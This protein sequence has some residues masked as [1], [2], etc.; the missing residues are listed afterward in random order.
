[1]AAGTKTTEAYKKAVLSFPKYLEVPG[2]L[3]ARGFFE[4]LRYW[5]GRTE[6]MVRDNLASYRIYLVGN[7]GTDLTLT[8][9]KPQLL[10]LLAGQGLEGIQTAGDLDALQRK[11]VRRS[12][13]QTAATLRRE[14]KRC[15][16]RARRLCAQRHRPGHR[17][18]GLD[19]NQELCRQAAPGGQPA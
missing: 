4:V 5:L 7:Y 19:A 13:A 8:L 9:T 12:L 15:I 17:P 2:E 10:G 11:L 16:D 14:R 1:M 18:E 3:K 6:Y